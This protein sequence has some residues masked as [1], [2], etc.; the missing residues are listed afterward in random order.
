[1][2]DG[3]L[4]I[5]RHQLFQLG[6]CGVVFE[7]GRAGLAKTPATISCGTLAFALS[8]VVGPYTERDLPRI[9]N[10]R[11]SRHRAPRPRR[12]NAM[13]ETVTAP[14]VFFS[15]SVFLAHAVDAYRMR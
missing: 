6:S 9:P 3:F 14:F 13:T 2:P 12:G 8:I 1:M 4:G 7:I 10:R 5:P 15:I 11:S